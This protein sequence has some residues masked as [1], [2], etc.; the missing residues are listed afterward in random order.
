MWRWCAVFLLLSSVV[1]APSAIAQAPPNNIQIENAKTGTNEWQLTA[2]GFTS[3]VIEGYAS[4]TS[5]NRGGRILL[6][7]N[8][9]EPTY[10]MDIFRMGYYNGLGGR[11][12]LPTITRTGVAQPMP[13][14][15]ASTGLVECQWSNPYVLDIPQTSDPTDWMSGIYL[16]KLTAGTSHTQQYITF[17]VRDDGRATDVLMAQS[18]NTYQAYNRWGGKSLYGTLQDPTDN[19]NRAV[20]VS[21]NRPYYGESTNGAGDFQ[22]WEMGMVRFLEASGYDVSYATNVDVDGDP[23]LL[24][25][26]RAFLSV[27]HDEYWSWKMRDNVENSRDAGVNLGFFSG[28]TSYWQVRYEASL[29]TGDPS[30]TL[31][32]YKESWASDPIQP[33][34]LKTNEFRYAPVNRSEDR[35]IGVMFVTQARPP[36]VVEDASHWIFSGTGLHNGDVLTNPDGSGFLGYEV[37]AVGPDSPA[38]VQRVAH[39]QATPRGANF[40][41][42]TVYRAPGGATVFASGSIAWD[43]SLLPMQQITRNVLARF[44]TGAFADTVPQRPALPGAFAAADIGD[45]GRPGF[46]SLAGAQSFVLNGG[47]RDRFRTSDALYYASQPLQGDG[48]IVVRLTTLQNYWDNRAGV[49]IRESLDPASKYV[50]LVGRPSESAGVLREGV[51]LL[52]RGSVGAGSTLVAQ[53]DQPLPDWL[54]LTRTGNVFDAAVS[55]DGVAWSAVGTTTVP[56]NA[57]VYVGAYVISGQ[58][59]VWTTARFDNVSVTGNPGTPVPPQ[60]PS[61]PSPPGGTTGVSTATSLSWSAPGAT[62]YDVA[63]GTTNPPPTVVTGQS[64]ATYAPTLA[65]NTTY[66]WQIVARNS[67]GT[68]PGP[69]WSFT[70]AAPPPPP[71][72]PASPAPANGATGVA[73]TPA[74]LSWTSTGATSYDVNFGAVNPPPRVSTGQAG[75]SYAPPALANSTTYFWQI[76]ARNSAGTT[77]GAMWSFTTA[78]AGQTPDDVVI[79]AAD[80]PPAGLH[81]AWTIVGDPTAAGGSKLATPDN[82]VANT[83]NA[84]AAPID[85]VDIPF[86]ANAGT[87]YAIWLRLQA[88]ANSKFNDSIYVQFSDALNGATPIY[89][90]NSTQGLFVNLA[91][92]GAASSLDGWGWQN[93]AYWLAQATT[94][95]FATTGTHTLRIQTREDGVQV[96]Q[97]VLSPS[98][99]RTLAPGP[100]GGDHTIVAKP[101]VTPPGT[102]TSPAPATGASGV[103]TPTTLTWSAANATSY[104]VRFGTA[105]PPPTVTTGQTAASY[106]PPPLAASTPYFWQIVAANSAGTTTGPVWSF[107]TA[108][109]APPPG[110]PAS[111]SPATAATGVATATTLTW[112]A[113]NATSYDVRFGT[114]N[115]PP[116]VTTGQAAASYTP[117]TLAA[118]TPYFWQIVARNSAG[119]TTGPVWSFTTAA[120]AP[121]PAD[122]VIYASDIP[123]SALHGSWVFA[124][125]ATSPAGTK[126][127][128][129]DLGVAN[130]ANALAAPVDYLDVT[131]TADAG[132]PYTLWLRLQATGNSKWND[133]VWVQ[134]SDARNGPATVYPLGTTQGLLVNLATNGG[135]SSLNQWGWEHGAYWLPQQTTTVTFATTGTHTIRIQTR[136]DG[137]QLDQIVLSPATYLTMAPGPV[138]DD[139]TIVSKP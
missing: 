36:F 57:A 106:T 107:T 42:M 21:F 72:A 139:R 135:A 103:P 91:T 88:V 117:P 113:A 100:V 111:P 92:D 23:A 85:Y 128:T 6:F 28:N 47:G 38:N 55:P 49:M 2:P 68:T 53:R 48:Q 71:A 17:A 86:T 115:P 96:D 116:A 122:I 120:A 102:P 30:R 26:H 133:A 50:S 11:R 90:L 67:T 66:F 39:S 24:R 76:A 56:M 89:P 81:G 137:V 52:S 138:G 112:S 44:I 35:M 8:T 114:A 27:G 51:E 10:T 131:F 74:P 124:A 80:V 94:V 61:S 20:K 4:L 5:V 15:D 7:V 63:F 3:R 118:G 134:F 19:A 136:E 127:V 34:F 54:R 95:S 70:T 119:T 13:A 16:V 32:G 75:A 82:G 41:D 121:P 84:S 60:T 93:G 46:V 129:P 58:Y 18:V 22:S 29:I 40:S 62:S 77:I 130:T 59:N 99:Y 108:A 37:D 125:D 64:A 73:I 14:V 31:V 83:A 132:V 101:A 25:S 78:A 33:S 110:T 1:R 109:P 126:V 9:A 65:G 104:D 69:V 12:M 98:R 79:Y 123:S 87:S 97:I 105:N 43:Y 45:V